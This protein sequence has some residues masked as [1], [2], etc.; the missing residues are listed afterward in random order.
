MKRHYKFFLV[1]LFFGI[2]IPVVTNIM[3]RSSEKNEQFEKVSTLPDFSLIT[4]EG[5]MYD[6]SCLMEEKKI[7][8]YFFNTECFYCIEG[9][10]SLIKKEG[11]YNSNFQIIA[12]SNEN[13][14]VVKSFVKNEL[15]FKNTKD[16][17]FLIDYSNEFF[18]KFKIEITPQLFIY[19][20]KRKLI[21]QYKG[22][23]DMNNVY[24]L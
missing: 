19:N 16:L 10:K 4:T 12:I 24:N 20:N 15:N 23:I 3:S 18:K 7:V 6:N 9:I 14:P 11:N 13:L 22:S 17:T 1:F 5:K 21:K 2:F 8:V